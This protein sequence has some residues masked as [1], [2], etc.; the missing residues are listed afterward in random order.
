MS[1][2][3][4]AF[5][6]LLK[7]EETN[8]RLD[9]IISAEL[10]TKK[11]TAREKKF[12]YNL[13]AGVVR[14]MSLFDWKIG[15]FYKGNYKKV[16]RKFKVIL[17]LAMYEIDIL[18]FIPPR[19]TV[20][21]YVNLA[22]KELD[23]RHASI[24]NGILR[25][26]LREG[27][28]LNPD[29]KFKSTAT[30]ISVKYSFPEWLIK[31]WI[32]YFGEQE[33]RRLCEA[34]NRRPKFDLRINPNKIETEQFCN[35]LSIHKIL[36]EPSKYFE[37][38][39]EIEDVQ[40]I[41]QLKLFERGYCSI[42]DESAMIVPQLLELKTGDRVLDACA[43]PGGKFTALLEMNVENA[44]IF[45]AE[46]NRDR[47]KTIIENC[48]RLGFFKANIIAADAVQYPFRK[49]FSKIII[50][51]PCSGSG[52]IQKHPD[53]KW[54][55]TEEE[56]G[57]FQTLQLDILTAMRDLIE[58]NGLLI[59]ST[60]SIDPAENEEVIRLFLDKH[61]NEFTIVEP[62]NKFKDLTFDN[63]FIRTFPHSHKM[64]G[65]FAVILKKCK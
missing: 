22:K 30:Q 1:A 51:A 63:K 58:K 10:N 20:N 23:Q 5:K 41:R 29:K 7:F 56:I 43:A 4:T 2:R 65:S 64:D 21:E 18:D 38:M 13:S 27:G 16:L 49:K 42:Q 34:F 33:V 54:R 25:T 3:Q 62:P 36:F 12:V 45:A 53:I 8:L 61:K 31:R 55:R 39:V 59:Y 11:L 19:A 50:D 6:I 40:K 24:T 35:L 37:N 32:D 48:R 28:K 46:I 52:T 60:C 14:N 26:Y 44:E 47:I 17:R 9:D 15:S 57:I